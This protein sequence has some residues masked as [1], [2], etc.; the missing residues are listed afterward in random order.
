METEEDSGSAGIIILQTEDTIKAGSIVYSYKSDWNE[1]KIPFYDIRN[2][3]MYGTTEKDIVSGSVIVLCAAF[4]GL[5]ITG[6]VV[7]SK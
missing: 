3:Q 7:L 1:L 6:A 4:V 2:F 5:I